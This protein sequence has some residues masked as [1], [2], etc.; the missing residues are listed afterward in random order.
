MEVSPMTGGNFIL[1]SDEKDELL[2]QY[3]QVE[4][5]IKEF[6]GGKELLNGTKRYVIWLKRC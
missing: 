2:K 4:S 1:T 5:L 6:I 3:P